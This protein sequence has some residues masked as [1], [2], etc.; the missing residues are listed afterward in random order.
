MGFLPKCGPQVDQIL[1]GHSHMFCA[2]V[3]QMHRTGRKDLGGG[4]CNCVGVHTSL[5]TAIRLPSCVKENRMLGWRLQAH[6]AQP[7]YFQWGEKFSSAM[8]PCCSFLEDDLLSY[9]QPRLFRDLHRTSSANSSTSRNPVP[10]LYNL[11]GHKKMTILDS[12][13]CNA[14]SLHYGHPNGFP[15]ITT[16]LSFCAD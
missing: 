4:F 15:E 2:T 3:V 11:P 14:R 5:S 7:L 16:A 8:G 13:S 10:P 1:V 9:H 12:V 6:T